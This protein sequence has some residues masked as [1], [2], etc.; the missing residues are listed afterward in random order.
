L[1]AFAALDLLGYAICEL[2]DFSSHQ[3]D[4]REFAQLPALPADAGF[5]AAPGQ[6]GSGGAQLRLIV[7]R[8][9]SELCKHILVECEPALRCLLH[10]RFGTRARSNGSRVIGMVLRNAGA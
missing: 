9:G 3:R 6:V 2:M 8:A 10:S 1:P 7:A 4:E 5:I